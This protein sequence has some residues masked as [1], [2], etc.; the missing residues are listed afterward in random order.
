[1]SLM[2]LVHWVKILKYIWQIRLLLLF[3]PDLASWHQIKSALRQRF[4]DNT[5]YQILLQQLQHEETQSSEST[6]NFCNKLKL[7]VQQI[8]NRITIEFSEQNSPISQDYFG[9]IPMSI[10]TVG[11]NY[12]NRQWP[13]LQRHSQ[14]P[15]GLPQAVKL[16]FQELTNTEPE[17]Q[18]AEYE[19]LEDVNDENYIEEDHDTE[20]QA[21]HKIP[22]DKPQG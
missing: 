8:I 14:N 20:E 4:G 3:R 6:T 5:N 9:K 16:V 10:N 12:N 7:M 15:H 22:T 18:L 19:T 1:M 13:T 2:Q 11:P 21:F 17:Q